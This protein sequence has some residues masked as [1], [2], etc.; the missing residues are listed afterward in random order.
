[1][2]DIHVLD[3][4]TANKIAAGEVVERPA[5]I[6][7]ELMENAMDAGADRIVVEADQ[8]GITRIRITDNGSGM[9]PEDL[10]LAFARHATSKI[11]QAEDLYA[12]TTMGFRGE[13][14]ASIA[15]VARV[16][17]ISSDKEDGSGHLY[18]IHG[19]QE[20]TFSEAS[21]T[22]GTRVEVTDLFFNTPAR[23]KFL[24]AASSETR[25]IS[26]VVQ[27]LAVARP[28]IS[29][30]LVLDGKTQFRTRGSGDLRDALAYVF[31]LEIT[32]TL[33]PVVAEPDFFRLEGLVG[34]AFLYRSS[35]DLQLFYIN[36]RL[37]RS[38]VLTRAL[39][40]AYRHMI[41]VRR[42]PVGV[43]KLT[44][45]PAAVD[46]NIHPSKLEVKFSM[47]ERIA[48]DLTRAVRQV[49]ESG[50]SIRT[51]VPRPVAASPGIRKKPEPLPSGLE[52][53]KPGTVRFSYRESIS[54]EAF[55][56][57][58]PKAGPSSGSYEPAQKSPDRQ[59]S[60]E[61]RIPAEARP[62]TPDG[63]ETVEPVRHPEFLELENL[64]MVGNT[65]LL[66]RGSQ[67]L[68]IVD[69]HAAHERLRFEELLR[70]WPEGT[71]PA[72]QILMEPVPLG[73]TLSLREK[74]GEEI[75]AL[76]NHGILLEYREPEYLLRGTP[77]GLSPEE[78]RD[79]LEEVLEAAEEPGETLRERILIR[80]ACS[81]AVKAGQT[82]SPREV[83]TLMEKLARAR[84][85]YT[86]PHGRPTVIRLSE[87]DLEKLFLRI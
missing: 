38:P 84:Y 76:R 81:G 32:R 73:L 2:P 60:M 24:K 83:R 13:A 16:R 7:K 6:V 14:L 5:S 29:V 36:G 75:L 64:G 62:D 49:L 39:E 22:R 53:L 66:A 23:R 33:K 86:C 9:G 8:G 48:G 85:P 65:Y 54:P 79:L 21:S 82:L 34:P 67:G 40:E 87:R 77:A 51:A 25:A 35:R 57:E 4:N 30:E 69:Q 78:T 44:V 71:E 58:E 72:S 74:L 11:R 17:M 3:E 61:P 20:V 43:L 42:Y 28:D 12:V 15:A 18:E 45:N 10:P 80:A 70:Q 46:V 56:A 55:L 52:D 19:G 41:P 68:Y 50:D 27:R 59:M 47:E 1:M 63:A 37:V 26:E 31:P